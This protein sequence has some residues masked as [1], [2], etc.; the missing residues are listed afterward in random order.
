MNGMRIGKSMQRGRLHAF[1][2]IERRAERGS[3]GVHRR[4]A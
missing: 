4:D 2:R 1:A 3:A